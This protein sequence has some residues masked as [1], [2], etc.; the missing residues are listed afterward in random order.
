MNKMDFL[1]NANR[2]NQETREEKKT[3][4]GTN[5]KRDVLD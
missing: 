1:N 3:L 2:L 5:Q 4:L